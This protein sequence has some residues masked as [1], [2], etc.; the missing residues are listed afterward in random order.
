MCSADDY[1]T[2]NGDYL[3]DSQNVRAAHEWCR[4]KCRRFMEVGAKMVVIANTNT[5]VEE[6][7]TYFNL[8]EIYGYM[9]FS[10]VVENRHGN[11]NVHDVP[12]ET[13]KKMRDRFQ[14]TL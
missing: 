9:V 8:A 14:I 2:R 10:V 5:T 3:W 4:R 11:T 1:H 7:Q 12:D 6:M 13:I